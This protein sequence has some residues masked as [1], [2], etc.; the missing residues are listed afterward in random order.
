MSKFRT[1]YERKVTVNVTCEACGKAY[2]YPHTF[3]SEQHSG[4]P[5]DGR[6]MLFLLDSMVEV[7]KLK[8]GNWPC[9]NCKYIQSWMAK[10]YVSSSTLSMGLLPPIPIFFIGV[11]LVV[12]KDIALWVFLG[13]LATGVALGLILAP[14]TNFRC[15][16]RLRRQRENTPNATP[17]IPTIDWS[18]WE[19]WEAKGSEKT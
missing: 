10:D 7:A 19:G 6:K 2:V 12:V 15:K 4:L 17:A 1:S 11:A 8:L 5:D 9:P 13:I 3:R 14:V 18:G 16:S